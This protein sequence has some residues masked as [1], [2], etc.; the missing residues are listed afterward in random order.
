MLEKHSEGVIAASACLGGIYAG[1]YWENR[2]S[3]P[4]AVLDAM[5]ESTEE[6]VSV[7]GDRWYGELQWNGIVEQHELNKYIIQVSTEFGLPLIST[8]DSHYP[9]KDS[10]K[11]RE[12]Y[13]RLGFLGKG[14][15]PEWLPTELPADVEE[16]G[17]EAYPKNGDEMWESY[18]YYFR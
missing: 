11:D 14:K 4:D 9:T 10:W 18:K 2:E 16:V 1:N 5:R 7:F 12:L 15:F 3:G 13:K 8:A 6:M 17:Y